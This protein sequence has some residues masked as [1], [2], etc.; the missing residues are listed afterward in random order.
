MALPEN[1]RRLI[2]LGI[3]SS[4]N[5]PDL[6]DM[7]DRC[8]DPLK[9]WTAAKTIGTMD[10]IRRYNITDEETFVQKFQEL[11]RI[12]L[13][14]L[15]EQVYQH[16][17][18]YFR[19]YKYNRET[20]FKYAYC[21]IVL[22]SLKGNTTEKVFDSWAARN[23]IKLIKPPPLL[24]EKFHTDRLQLNAS[25]EVISFISVK[26]NSFS[27]NYMQYTDVFAGLETISQIKGIPWQ[28]YYR[29]QNS[30]SLIHFNSLSPSSRESVKIWAKDYAK[31]E[32]DLVARILKTL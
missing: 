23:N 1:Y 14:T 2:A 3:D 32:R 4:A 11:S 24:D 15:T 8:N 17:L 12:P 19:R 10:M 16:Q 18:K 28:I 13:E 7:T 30:F 9:P 25:R 5:L 31:E 22:N 6:N 20:I 29:T 27:Y 26:P 21:C